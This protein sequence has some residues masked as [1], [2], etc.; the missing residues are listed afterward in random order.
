MPNVVGES[1]SGS[2]WLGWHQLLQTKSKISHQFGLKVGVRLKKYDALINWSSRSW[3]GDMLP[4][5]GIARR[6]Q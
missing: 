1:S 5:L 6:T 4:A 2:Y 3:V